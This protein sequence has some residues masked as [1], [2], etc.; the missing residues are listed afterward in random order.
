MRFMERVLMP[1]SGQKIALTIMVMIII[2]I[3]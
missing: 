2:A 1:V 3:P